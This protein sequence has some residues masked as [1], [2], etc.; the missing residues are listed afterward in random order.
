V[1]VRRGEIVI[2][3]FP[4]SDQTASKILPAL[5]VQANLWNQR[6]DDTILAPITSSDNFTGIT[7]TQYFIDILTSEGQ[8]TGLIFNSVVRCGNLITYNQSLILRI[9]GKLSSHAMQQIDGCLKVALGI[10]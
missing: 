5:V 7:S 8:Q 9:I 2:V 1:N 3:D 10:P 4:Y 6:L